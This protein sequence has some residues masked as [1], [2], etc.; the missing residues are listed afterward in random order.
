MDNDNITYTRQG[1][2]PVCKIIYKK[3]LGHDHYTATVQVE[4]KLP[5][6]G[7]VWRSE[8]GR[9]NGWVIDPNTEPEFSRF[10][11]DFASKSAATKWTNDR[12]R[13]ELRHRQMQKWIRTEAGLLT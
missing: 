12:L 9:W 13:E 6:S 5:L 11:H 10:R 8:D 1:K 2:A 4:D 3:T 7:E